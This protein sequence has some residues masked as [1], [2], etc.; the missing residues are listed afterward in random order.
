MTPCCQARLAIHYH[1]LLLTIALCYLSRLDVQLLFQ[2][3]LATPPIVVSLPCYLPS[4]L[5]ALPSISIST[6]SPLSCAGGGA[7][8]NINLSF[9]QQR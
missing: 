5:V 8:N 7:W 3:P 2:V 4:R 6:P 9:I 1:A